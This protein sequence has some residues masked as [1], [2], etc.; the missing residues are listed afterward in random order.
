M[1]KKQNN[2]LQKIVENMQH[3]AATFQNTANE[4]TV[5]VAEISE[6]KKKT[7]ALTHDMEHL[8]IE[9]KEAKENVHL[10]KAEVDLL[11]KHIYDGADRILDKNGKLYKKIKRDF[12]RYYEPF[13]D[14]PIF[15]LR[16][17]YRDCRRYVNKQIEEPDKDRA[18]KYHKQKDYKVMQL[19]IMEY[20]ELYLK[21]QYE[22]FLQ[23]LSLDQLPVDQKGIITQTTLF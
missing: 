8:K 12:F 20:M 17:I 4:M 23:E 5:I 15:E 22:K 10:T 14:K 11:Q 9:V 3:A 19:K 7:E 13:D 1:F 21:P 6:V 2:Q 18:F 16:T